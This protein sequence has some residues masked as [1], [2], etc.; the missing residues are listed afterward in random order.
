MSADRSYP[1]GCFNMSGNFDHRFSPI[2]VVIYDQNI[3]KWHFCKADAMLKR[4]MSWFITIPLRIGEFCTSKMVLR[5]S[6][7]CWSNFPAHWHRTGNGRFQNQPIKEEV[8]LRFIE[9]SSWGVCKQVWRIIW[10]IIFRHNSLHWFSNAK[11]LLWSKFP[12]RS[13]YDAFTL[14]VA[15]IALFWSKQCVHR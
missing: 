15:D 7:L 3:Y 14:I 2:S 6:R 13:K 11:I 8:K 1:Q 9:E 12:T 4:M 10:A 5:D